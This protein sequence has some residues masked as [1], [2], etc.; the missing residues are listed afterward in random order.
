MQNDNGVSI[1]CGARAHT[2]ENLP[3]HGYHYTERDSH[4]TLP[5]NLYFIAKEMYDEIIVF[6][7]TFAVAVLNST[8]CTRAELFAMCLL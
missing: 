2:E 4:S 5:L 7:C 1:I 8:L 6:V 3:K